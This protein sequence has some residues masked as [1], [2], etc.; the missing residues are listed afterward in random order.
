MIETDQTKMTKKTPMVQFH[1][2]SEYF[3]EEKKIKGLQCDRVEDIKRKYDYQL[4]SLN[5]MGVDMTKSETQDIEL[6][7]LLQQTSEMT[8]DAAKKQY[9]EFVDETKRRVDGVI[10]RLRHRYN[11]GKKINS[12]NKQSL[13]SKQTFSNEMRAKKKRGKSSISHF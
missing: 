2:L 3:D 13:L 6:S 10:N 11:I 8:A 5:R 12:I 4:K 1:V 9:E 7:E